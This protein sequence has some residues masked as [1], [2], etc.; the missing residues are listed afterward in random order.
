MASKTIVL[1]S[2]HGFCAGVE[3][4]VRV[5]E[6]CLRP[7]AGPV[8]CLHEIVHNT[9]IIRDLAARGMVFVNDVAE[10]PEGATAL[11][12]AH[13]VSPAV[14]AAAA[15]RRLNTI[16]A[17][18]PFVTKVHSEVKRYAAAGYTVLLVGHRAHDEVVGVAGEAPERVTVIENETE[19]RRVAVP[20]PAKVAVLSQTTLSPDETGRVM[21]ALRERFPAI[22][23][24]A[25]SDICYATR[26]R[27]QA[28]RALAREVDHI[29]VLGAR[30]SS[31]SNRLVEVARAE[32]CVATLVSAPGDVEAMGLDGVTRLGLTAGASTPEYVVT[33]TIARLKVLGF[34]R[35]EER[36]VVQEDLHFALPP[37][38][39]ARSR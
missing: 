19:A 21:N 31:N 7:D 26:N 25:E 30:N 15:A 38:A 23:T 3:R 10:I 28:V 8:Y 33:E 32:G 16:D 22:R 18:C 11:F 29:L 34:E 36:R 1:V 17:T 2:P 20:D 37:T 12:S 27:Q 14:R 35:V 13:G 39:A 4:A 9:Q 5:A 6:A 24:P